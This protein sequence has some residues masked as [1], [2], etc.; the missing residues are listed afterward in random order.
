MN[1]NLE[2]IGENS[3]SDS[4][5]YE[6][7]KDEQIDPKLISDELESEFPGI[8]KDMLTP[9]LVSTIDPLSVSLETEVSLRN[10]F[11]TPDRSINGVNVN[12]EF[13][14]KIQ[15]RR[16]TIINDKITSGELHPQLV[17]NYLGEDWERQSI[18]IS[19]RSLSILGRVDLSFEEI[20]AF[21]ELRKEYKGDFYYDQSMLSNKIEGSTKEELEKLKTSKTF[22]RL[23]PEARAQVISQSMGMTETNYYE[24]KKI[25]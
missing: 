8:D 20:A 17:K 12:A 9:E 23:H 22:S 11:S 19:Q 15:D 10:K 4:Q 21:Q 13:D 1:F 7:F 24:P 3:N 5:K 18:E 6:V 25:S 16:R 2:M 14:K